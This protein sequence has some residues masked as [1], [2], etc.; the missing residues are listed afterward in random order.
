[1]T[2]ARR[3]SVSLHVVCWAAAAATLAP[4]VSAGGGGELRQHIRGERVVRITCKPAPSYT[5][6]WAG[7]MTQKLSLMEATTDCQ[8]PDPETGDRSAELSLL[9]GRCSREARGRRDC[10]PVLQIQSSPL[11]ERHAS[12]YR[13]PLTNDPLP[14]KAIKVRGVP[15][16]LFRR[17][18][19][20]LQVYAGRT[21][22]SIAAAR[23]SLVLAVAARVAPAPRLIV[24]PAGR[25]LAQFPGNTPPLAPA[26]RLKEPSPHVL[27][28]TQPC[29]RGDLKSEKTSGA[30]EKNSSAR[31]PQAP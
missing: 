29:F 3:L 31:S 23:R 4:A 19:W 5:A 1:V 26:D 27:R 11:C 17:G 18:E 8:R 22:I 14:F 2:I 6:Y 10:A 24:P 12:L 25:P 28:R 13:K 9:Y 30:A 16:A 7:A 15:G 20:I 21:T